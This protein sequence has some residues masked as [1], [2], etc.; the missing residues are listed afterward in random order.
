MACRSGNENITKYLV[1]NGAD[2]N[3]ENKDGKTPLFYSC[4]IRYANLVKYLIE[5]NAKVNKEINTP[6]QNG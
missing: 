1:E 6:A 2:I 3:K 5:N 4:N